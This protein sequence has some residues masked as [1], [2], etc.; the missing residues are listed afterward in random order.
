MYRNM[1]LC[2]CTCVWVCIGTCVPTC[3]SERLMLSACQFLSTLLF[4]TGSLVELGA[5]Q[6]ASQGSPGIPSFPPTSAGFMDALHHVWILHGCRVP[7]LW[8]PVLC[9]KLSTD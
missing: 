9:S 3:G 5:H 4:G 8:V 6:L 2:V 7:K 1:H